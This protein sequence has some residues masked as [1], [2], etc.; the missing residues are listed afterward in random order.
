MINFLIQTINSDGKIGFVHAFAIGY[1]GVIAM[2]VITVAIVLA[3][4]VLRSIGLYV[5]AKRQNVN[6]PFIAF[7]PIAWMYT[8]CKIIGNV[9]IFNFTF[10]RVAL[11]FAIIFGVSE[12]MSIAYNALVYYPLVGNLLIGGKEIYIVSDTLVCWAEAPLMFC[13]L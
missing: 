11:I 10:A 13:W 1:G 12:I 3:F 9:K 8:A 5:L 7:I 4:Y 6:C 2:A